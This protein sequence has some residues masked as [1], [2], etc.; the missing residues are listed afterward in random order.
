MR[1][2]WSINHVNERREVSANLKLT[3]GRNKQRSPTGE[4]HALLSQDSRLAHSTQISP[5]PSYT[6]E[7]DF[8]ETQSCSS[9]ARQGGIHMRWQGVR[10]FPLADQSHPFQGCQEMSAVQPRLHSGGESH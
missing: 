9:K 1:E 2:R 5:Q 10:G 8:I 4:Q 3:A 7:G 6:W